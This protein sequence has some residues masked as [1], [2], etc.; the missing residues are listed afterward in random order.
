M[1]KGK[2]TTE[3]LLTHLAVAAALSGVLCSAAA[4]FAGESIWSSD[5]VDA[6]DVHDAAGDAAA[7]A[8][9]SDL[10]RSGDSVEVNLDSNR[11]C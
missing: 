10:S 7:A 3:Y 5:G 8:D 6:L 11:P 1:L 4:A 2:I 9:A